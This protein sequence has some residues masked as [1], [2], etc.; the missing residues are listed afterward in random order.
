MK[1]ILHAIF[2][3]ALLVMPVLAQAMPCNMHMMDMP[4]QPTAEVQMMVMGDSSEPCPSHKATVQAEPCNDLMVMADCLDIDKI[5]AAD[6]TTFTKLVKADCSPI[7]LLP[8]SL[9]NTT[10][11]STATPRAPPQYSNMRAPSIS[12]IL[13]TNRFRV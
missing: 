2:T 4:Q 10:L 5:T 8:A 3:V 9:T 6:N 11:L 13:T 12:L 1:N 7:A